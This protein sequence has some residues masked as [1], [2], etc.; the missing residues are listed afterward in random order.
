MPPTYQKAFNFLAAE[1]GSKS[2]DVEEACIAH[3][4]WYNKVPARDQIHPKIGC[5]VFKEGFKDDSSGNMW[6]ME[7]LA[8]VSLT[9]ARDRDKPGYV[10]TLNRFANFLDHVP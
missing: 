7:K 8:P 4:H 5:P 2:Y 1:F 6:P 9:V 10:N 3:V